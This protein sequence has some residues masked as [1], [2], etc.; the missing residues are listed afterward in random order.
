MKVSTENDDIEEL[1]LQD[2]IEEEIINSTSGADN[3]GYGEP[4][5]PIFIAK[6]CPP[7]LASTYCYNGGTCYVDYYADNHYLPFCK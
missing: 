4:G 1:L 2:S 3:N 5:D 6:S 7:H